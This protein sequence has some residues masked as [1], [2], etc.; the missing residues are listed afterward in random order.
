M[1]GS[2]FGAAMNLYARNGGRK[3]LNAAERQRFLRATMAAPSRIRLFCEV[4]FWSGSRISEAL[5]LTANAI[6]LDDCVVTLETLKRRKAGIVRQVPLPA[7]LARQLGREFH[8]RARQRN[9][10]LADERLWPWSRATAWR[11]VKELMCSADV[12]GSAAMP[13]GLRHTFG[14]MAFQRS[15][16]PHIVQRWLGH[17]S[18]E[19]TAIYGDIAGREEREFAAR[20]WRAN[21]M[22]A[23]R[24][25]Q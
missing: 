21:R 13:K 6:D 5:A 9:S 4:L 23:A 1:A 15:I 17:A 7:G 25:R 16:P 20:M 2:N 22:N 3:Y 24:G 10:V 19:T 12:G 11:R 8:L 18:L 14:V